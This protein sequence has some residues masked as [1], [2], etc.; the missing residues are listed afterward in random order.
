MLDVMLVVDLV[1]F[2]ISAKQEGI[3]GITSL[4]KEMLCATS[5]KNLVTLQYFVEARM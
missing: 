2:I 4:D 1:I 5:A 3:N